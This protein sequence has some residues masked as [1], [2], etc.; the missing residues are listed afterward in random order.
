MMANETKLFWGFMAL[1][2]ISTCDGQLPVSI[3]DGGVSSMGPEQYYLSWGILA[4][5]LCLAILLGSIVYKK[6]PSWDQEATRVFAVTIVIIAGLFLMTAGYT[7]QQVAPM[8]GLLG[9]MIGY[10]FGKSSAKD[11]I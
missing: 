4:F 5:G 11:K 3:E 9:T 2:L 1:V 10:I 8:Y 6:N 7:D